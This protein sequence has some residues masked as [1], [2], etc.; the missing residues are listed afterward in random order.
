M[1]KL[2]YIIP[3]L[4]FFLTTN[5][6]SQHKRT[7]VSKNRIKEYKIS[8]IT[9][10][11][12][13]TEKEAQQ[14]WPIYNSHEAMLDKLRKEESSSLRKLIAD[15]NDIDN[16]SESDAKQIITSIQSIKAKTHAIHQEYFKKLKKIL[17]YKKILKLQVAEREFK[18][19]LFEKM[20]K[21]RKVN[22]E[23]KKSK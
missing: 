3:V 23:E 14:F 7:K 2:L 22:K 15:N 11:L 5:V 13:L 16:V 6:Y 21:R 20:R 1:K 19:I 4:V 18:R 17:S 9:K 10:E 12:S 8:H